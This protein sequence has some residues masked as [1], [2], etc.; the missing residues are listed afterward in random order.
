MRR[1]LV[2]TGAWYALVDRKDPDHA[3]VHACLTEYRGR[4][5]TTDYIGDEAITLLRYRVGWKIACTFGE[6]LFDGNVASL[7]ELTPKDKKNAWKI[8]RQDSDKSFSFTDCTSFA[9]MDRL[10]IPSAVAIDR[11]FRA[12]GVTC[13]P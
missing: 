5:V 8:F 10:R 3:R 11:D 13:I 7:I 9:L 6:Q 4:L 1:V 12:Y 2:D